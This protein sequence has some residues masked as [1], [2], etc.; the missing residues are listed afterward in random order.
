MEEAEENNNQHNDEPLNESPAGQT[1]P[2]GS[3]TAS[4]IVITKKRRSRR[5]TV[6]LGKRVPKEVYGSDFED[7]AHY[8]RMGL[9]EKQA[10][11]KELTGRLRALQQPEQDST[12]R[13]S[14]RLRIN[15]IAK[16]TKIRMELVEDIRMIRQEEEYARQENRIFSVNLRNVTVR[17]KRA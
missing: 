14:E 3:R 6:G 11:L 13:R 16:L 10:A 17:K 4:R 7:S 1:Q 15:K 2:S 8:S 9:E 5:A 12:V